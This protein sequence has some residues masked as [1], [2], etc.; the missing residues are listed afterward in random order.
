[1]LLNKNIMGKW[2]HMVLQHY[3]PRKIIA[4]GI[5]ETIYQTKNSYESLLLLNV[6]S[7]NIYNIFT[8]DKNNYCYVS[9]EKSHLTEIFQDITDTR[10]RIIPFWKVSNILTSSTCSVSST[11]T[12]SVKNTLSTFVSKESGGQQRWALSSQKFSKNSF[13]QVVQYENF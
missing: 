7:I 8:L 6:N 9:W 5:N 12:V 10:Q 1:M 4:N 11:K 3:S 2:A 13:F